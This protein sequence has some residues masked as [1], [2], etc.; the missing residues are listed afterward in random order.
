MGK[1]S[2]EEGL[3]SRVCFEEL[4]SFVRGRVQQFVQDLLE[5][6]RSV[7]GVIGPAVSISVGPGENKEYKET[8]PP[9]AA[10]MGIVA[11]YYR[12]RGDPEGTLTAVVPAACSRFFSSAVLIL[13]PQ[14]LL[15]N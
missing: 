10:Y 2:I 5:D 9:T 14:N 6:A 7:P 12:E 4:E 8:F 3:P 1:Q 11:D 13:S 15:V